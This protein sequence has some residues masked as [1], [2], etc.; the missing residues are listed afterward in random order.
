M[1]GGRL[2]LCV[3]CLLGPWGFCGDLGYRRQNVCVSRLVALLNPVRF[4]NIMPEPY[5]LIN[6]FL[7]G[8]TQYLPRGGALREGAWS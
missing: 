2:G 8:L 1:D 3:S 5:L 6:T 7:Q 4:L